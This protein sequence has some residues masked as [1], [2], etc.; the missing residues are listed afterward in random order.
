MF[1]SMMPGRGALAAFGARAAGPL[2]YGEGF[3]DPTRKLMDR[4]LQSAGGN[5]GL[6]A[7]AMW[8]DREKKR[9]RNNMLGGG[10]LL[11]LE[12]ESYFGGGDMQM[13]QAAAKLKNL[14][15]SQGKTT[16]PNGPE[17]DPIDPRMTVQGRNQ[18]ER[19]FKDARKHIK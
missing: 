7:K 2:Q 5:Y 19:M 14:A 18:Y 16:G 9:E 15:A 17:E 8:N 3:D 12:N 13:L 11:Q 1:D 6:A 4:A 10:T